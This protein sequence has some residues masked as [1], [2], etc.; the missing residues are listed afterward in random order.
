M[1]KKSFI[2]I[3]SIL[4]LAFLTIDLLNGDSTWLKFTG[5]VLCFAYTLKNAK[6]IRA[7]AMFFT[8]IAD[9]CL[10]VINDYYEIGIAVFIIVQL[11][12]SHFLGNIDKAFYSRMLIFRFIVVALMT[13]L[14]IF[15]KKITIM[16]ELIVLY[17][18]NILINTLHAYL[19]DQKALA[20]GFTLFVLC[21]ICVGLYNINAANSIAA[22]GMW[23]FYLPSQ[24]LIT[25][26]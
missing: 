7:V 11:L 22:F 6:K 4:Y 25:S 16:N 10:L 17:F 26:F 24:V 9:T 13:A 8:L 15:N 14:L 12:Y 18:S 1:S 23:L 5:I 20:I 21:D 2:I 3:E 19:S